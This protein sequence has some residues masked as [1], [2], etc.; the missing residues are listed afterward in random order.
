MFYF[1][2]TVAAG[3]APALWAAIAAV[4]SKVGAQLPT[5]LVL[6]IDGNFFVTESEVGTLDGP[7]KGRVLYL[8]LPLCRLMKPDELD[9]VIAHE[10]A[11]FVGHDTEYGLKFGPIYQGIVS[12]YVEMNAG[13]VA[14]MP[15]QMLMGY[16]LESF[17]TAVSVIDR[18]RELAA[19][20]VGARTASPRAIASSLVKL[21]LYGPLLDSLRSELREAVFDDKPIPK[22]REVF[23]QRVA[24][25]AASR[26]TDDLAEKS[27]PHPTDSHPQLDVRLKSLLLEIKDVEGEAFEVPPAS[28]ALALFPQADALEQSIWQGIEDS[29]VNDYAAFKAAPPAA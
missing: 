4:A 12:S 13:G 2:K 20:A 10:L 19:D 21:H 8:S 1:S 23:A 18:E 5:H 26:A 7:V 29:A 6:G 28:S 17:S 15:V 25:R 3:D 24:D 14:A 27:L 22:P 11:H 16:F 9:A